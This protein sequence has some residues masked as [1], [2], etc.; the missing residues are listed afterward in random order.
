MSAGPK[1]GQ[2][3]SSI[4]AGDLVSLR[5]SAGIRVRETELAD[6]RVHKPLMF[7]PLRPACVA[8]RANKV[9]RWQASLRLCLN[10][11]RPN[12]CQRARSDGLTNLRVR[13]LLRL[14]PS[15]SFTR[16][17]GTA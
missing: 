8:M 12:E 5:G 1:E 13:T 2:L 14:D 6:L 3:W 11:A 7:C 16:T 10:R 4:V 15:D 17:S 9:G